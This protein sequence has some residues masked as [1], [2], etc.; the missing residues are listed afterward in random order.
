M[1]TRIATTLRFPVCLSK[2]DAFHLDIV[3]WTSANT[4]THQCQWGLGVNI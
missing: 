4:L 1:E 2:L 3:W